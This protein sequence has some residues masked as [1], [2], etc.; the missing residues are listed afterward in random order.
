MAELLFEGY[1]P[2]GVFLGR[3]GMLSCVAAGKT[4]GLVIES[5]GGI[6]TVVPVQ[7]GQVLSTA[8]QKSAL[9]GDLLT[10]ELARRLSI[11]PEGGWPAR[12]K[13]DDDYT[14]FQQRQCVQGIKET[15][16]QLPEWTLPSVA[17]VCKI[18]LQCNCTSIQACLLTAALSEVARI[19]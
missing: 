14:A 15:L 18:A 9:A 8:L 1:T 16:C 4:T 17:Q 6:S 3:S 7:D 2:S 19:Q 11:T 5:G 12:C 13:H 10:D